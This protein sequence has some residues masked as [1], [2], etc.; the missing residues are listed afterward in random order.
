MLI[1][2]SERKKIF[3]YAEDDVEH[4][5]ASTELWQPYFWLIHNTLI[6]LLEYHFGV[7]NDSSKRFQRL[8]VLDLGSGT[9][10]EAL[11]VLAAF[12]NAQLIA[13]DLS[14]PMH[15][16]LKRNIEARFTKEDFQRRCTLIEGDAFGEECE[17]ER[18]LACLSKNGDSKSFDAV[19]TGY[20]LHHYT[21]DE[22]QRLYHRIHQLLRPGGIFVN[23]D[24]FTFH[25]PTV[26]KYAVDFCI[27]WIEKQFSHPDSNL[28]AA[29]ESLGPN[30]EKLRVNWIQHCKEENIPLPFE[31]SFD[32][33]EGGPNETRSESDI[34]R[35]VGF[36]E[37]ACP[38]RYWL[39]G[40]VCAIK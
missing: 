20:M 24:N 30:V 2:Q 15:E 40:I 7:V 8:A 3:F 9:G 18:L 38:F 11:R 21:A 35:E 29:F 26:A 34:L 37:I 39:A 23:A 19:I 16:A 6:S 17:V 33:F 31:S 13:V 4:Y 27:R 36:R 32:T 28:K 10:A 1:T 22:K 12:P 14:P 5:D 25:S